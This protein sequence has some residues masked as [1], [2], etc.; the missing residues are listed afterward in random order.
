MDFIT[1]LCISH[2]H[3]IPFMQCHLHSLHGISI[4]P[5]KLIGLLYMHMNAVW[6]SLY[7]WATKQLCVLLTFT[8]NFAPLQ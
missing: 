4:S 2:L 6:Q 8:E 7:V 5:N 3:F 1:V